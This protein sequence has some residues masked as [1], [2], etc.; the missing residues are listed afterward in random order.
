MNQ[1][2]W[3][4]TSLDWSE[5]W[6][7]EAGQSCNQRQYEMPSETK[8]RAYKPKCAG[9]EYEKMSRMR[10]WYSAND[11]VVAEKYGHHT[12]ET[13][14]GKCGNYSPMKSRHRF[15]IHDLH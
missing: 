9:D 6:Q 15:L 7:S 8:Y 12:A 2:K 1:F 5:E 10:C 3:Y 4:P 13:Y 14:Q 11:Y